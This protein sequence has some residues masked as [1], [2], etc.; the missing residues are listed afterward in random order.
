[1]LIQLVSDTLA[2]CCKRGNASLG[3]SGFFFPVRTRSAHGHAYIAEGAD[4]PDPGN[5]TVLQAVVQPVSHYGVVKLTGMARATASNNAAAFAQAFEEQTSH[6]LE[7]MAW[8][9]EAAFFRD[10]SGLITQFNGNPGATVGPHTVDDVSHLRPGME[11]DLI[12]ETAFTR[13]NEDI[14]ISDVDWVNR[15]V[16]FETPV[17]SAL[18]DNDG[19]F[20]ADS[21]DSTGAPVT[22]EPLGLA[23]SLASTGVYLGIDRG[24]VREWQARTISGTRFLDEDLIQR[25]RV[26]LT[27]VTGLPLSGI[28]SAYAL[29]THPNIAETLFKLVIPRVQYT[30]GGSFDLLNTSEV[31]LGNM[32]IITTPNCPSSKAYLGDWKYSQTLYLPG[33]ELKMDEELNGSALKWV[34]NKDVGQVFF[35]EYKQY[36]VKRPNAFVVYDTL[37]ELDR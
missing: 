23:A 12:D 34:S 16:T 21:Q 27:Q 10:G 17:A 24:T 6:T 9:D 13:H 36:V 30:M 14:V 28:S 5:T 22:R 1:M 3:G 32:P 19:I 29:L 7:S 8:Y 33:G 2:K 35:R 18:D 4:L 25:G 11:V 15:T 37:S 31:K 26:F 20:I